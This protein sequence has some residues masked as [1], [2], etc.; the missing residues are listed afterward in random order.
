MKIHT[1]LANRAIRFSKEV[2]N[3][4]F[5]ERESGVK[6]KKGGGGVKGPAP[7]PTS[8]LHPKKYWLK[9]LLN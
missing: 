6:F 2:H 7:P 8:S 1:L 5:A 4:S 9:D 3:A